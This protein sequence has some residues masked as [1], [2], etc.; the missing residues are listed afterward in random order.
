M[1]GAGQAALADSVTEEPTLPLD[2]GP[3]AAQE[4]P[5]TPAFP[6]APEGSGPLLAAAWPLLALLAR[7]R[8]GAVA[9]PD[10]LKAGCIAALRRYETEAL[11]A[12]LAAD[13]V[14]AGRYAL[15][16]A[17]DEQ[18]LGTPWGDASDWSAGSLLATFHN[19]TWGGEKVFA[20]VDLALAGGGAQR[21]LAELLFHLLSLGFQGR[22]RLRRDG[23]TEVEALRE[24]LYRALRPGLGEA[25]PPAA[26]PPPAPP[27]S[28]WARGRARRLRSWPP[29]WVVGA[30]AAV[31][32][33]LV[34]SSYEALLYARAE[35]LATALLAVDSP[36]PQTPPRA[37]PA[38]PAIPTPLPAASG[39]P[40][41]FTPGGLGEFPRPPAPGHLPASDP[42]G[43]LGVYAPAPAEPSP[44][45]APAEPAPP[46]RRR[47]RREER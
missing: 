6:P 27:R 3:T 30:G 24:R 1:F 29:I 44:A 28:R 7:L 4:T 38:L 31:L 19:E 40:I 35:R 42:A 23:T 45:A 33:L 21:D 46:P 32:A 36:P 10:T 14:H 16:S 18:V 15:C 25:P 34:F 8:A 20:L 11:R 9:R 17:L 2:L 41:T 47:P 37:G 22:Y 43:G 5:E 26:A 12:G 13:I 39:P